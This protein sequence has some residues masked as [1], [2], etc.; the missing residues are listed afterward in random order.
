MKKGL[1]AFALLLALA[2]LPFAA[3]NMVVFA[4]MVMAKGLAC[5]LYTSPSPRD[6]G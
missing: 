3:S 5:L 6:R 1:V 2:L 4:T